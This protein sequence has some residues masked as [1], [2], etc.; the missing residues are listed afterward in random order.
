MASYRRRSRL[1]RKEEAKN[2]RR[3]YLYGI[4]SL[5]L[6]VVIVFLGLPAL[7]RMA[8]FL[9]E[10]RSSSL[11]IE[12][13]DT[14]PPPPP[15]SYSLP[16][17]TNKSQIKI[18]GTS[19]I[20]SKVTIYVNGQTSKDV[21]TDA[22][23]IFT[24]QLNLKGERSEITLQA[25]DQAGN[26]SQE[27]EKIVIIFD[28]QPPEMEISSPPE[29]STT[30][31]KQIEIKGKINEEATVL[32]NDRLVIL[33]QENNFNYLYSLSEG[34]NT[35]KIKAQDEAENLTEKEIKITYQPF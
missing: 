9:G 31:E 13:E 2:L 18:E 5:A 34:E 16:R 17:A 29:N 21:V 26:K 27:S 24:A 30:E 3:V 33:D 25:E 20:G 11:V 22:S 6:I 19:E 1:T 10:L 8:A 23:G 4:L 14:V 32:I 12:K 28:D 7:I 35:I 15:Q